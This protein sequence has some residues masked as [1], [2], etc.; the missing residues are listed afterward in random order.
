MAQKTIMMQDD[1]VKYIKEESRRDHGRSFSNMLN[2]LL[3][4]GKEKLEEE[5]NLLESVRSGNSQ[6][7]P[8]LI[9]GRK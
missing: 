7:D 3:E 8:S 4:K 1:M 2:V 9:G 5:K 6:I